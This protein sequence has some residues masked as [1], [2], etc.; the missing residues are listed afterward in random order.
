M[1]AAI[2][3]AA[4]FA[5]VTAFASATGGRVSVRVTVMPSVRFS[6]EV[7]APVRTLAT[8]GGTFYVLPVKES[9]AAHGGVA[10]SLSFEGAEAFLRRSRGGVEGDLRVF[11]PEGSEGRVV[12]TVLADGAPPE[13]RRKR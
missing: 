5:P 2:V 12:V 11:V 6:Q 3:L 13:I 4:L 1:R 8:S 10:P 7:G 9:L